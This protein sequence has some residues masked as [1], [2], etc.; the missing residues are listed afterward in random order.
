MRY[1]RQ[2]GSCVSLNPNDRNGFTYY[3]ERVRKY[4][5]LE[6]SPYQSETWLSS[7]C[8]EEDKGRDLE[9]LYKMDNPGGCYLTTILCDILKYPDSHKDLEIMR[10]FRDM[11][12]QKDLRYLNILMEYDT[13]GPVI[14][15]KLRLDPNSKK[16]ALMFA[17]NYIAPIV[18]F[19]QNNL[20]NEA[21]SK[22]VEMVNILKNMY[23][24]TLEDKII[25]YDYS[26]GGHGY[27][28]TKKMNKS[29]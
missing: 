17:K 2:C 26:R 11:V 1:Y 3:C 13:I 9:Y 14:A 6:D 10:K 15:T 16:I 29:R 12:L 22:Y 28:F 23:G 27:V 25:D 20:Y 24:V 19:I 18:V 7:S 5:R 8:Y 4:R 21:I